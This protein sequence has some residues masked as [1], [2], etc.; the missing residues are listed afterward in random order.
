MFASNLKIIKL[1]LNFNVSVETNPPYYRCNFF[2]LKTKNTRCTT[3][4]YTNKTVKRR[5]FRVIKICLKIHK[6]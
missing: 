3:C 5:V 4:F 2:N 1:K 6:N